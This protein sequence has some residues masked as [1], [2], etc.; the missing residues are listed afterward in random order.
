[1]SPHTLPLE[2]IIQLLPLV[3]V[4]YFATEGFMVEN[5]T[6]LFA[7]IETADPVGGNLEV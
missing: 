7:P 6:A 1:L 5:V 4:K 3:F 2:S